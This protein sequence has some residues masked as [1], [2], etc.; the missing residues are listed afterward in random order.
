MNPEQEWALYE[1]F[2][3]YERLGEYRQFT[4]SLGPN[5]LFSKPK[6]LLFKIKI[7]MN[8]PMRSK[9]TEEFFHNNWQKQLEIDISSYARKTTIPI[10]GWLSGII[11]H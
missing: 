8:L 4:A 10:L 6:I 1:Y 9:F 11:I 2:G 7:K 3:T 5:G